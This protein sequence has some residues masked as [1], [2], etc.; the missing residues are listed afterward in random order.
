MITY[1][2]NILVT[3]LH[4]VTGINDV[5]KGLTPYIIIQNFQ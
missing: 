2:Q 3:N 1:F 5:A 4:N